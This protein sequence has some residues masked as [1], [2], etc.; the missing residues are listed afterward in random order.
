MTRG[1]VGAVALAACAWSSALAASTS[2]LKAIDPA[3]FQSTIEELAKELERPMF[4]LVSAG[5]P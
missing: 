3:A 5:K 2:G 4:L 1:L